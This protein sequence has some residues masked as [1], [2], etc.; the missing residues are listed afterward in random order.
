[1]R[2]LRRSYPILLAALAAV[3]SVV[4]FPRL[5]ATMAVHWDLDGNPNGWMPRVV[6]AFFGPVIVLAVALGV[7]VPIDRVV[8]ALVGAVFVAI[9][10]AMPRLGPNRWYGIRTPW[11]LY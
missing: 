2:S 8:P 1:M 7:P 10:S 11:T 3:A 9:G 6:G 5:P 4:V